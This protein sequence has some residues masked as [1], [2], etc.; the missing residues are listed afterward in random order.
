MNS[1]TS[2]YGSHSIDPDMET[3]TVIVSEASGQENLEQGQVQENRLQRKRVI[4]RRSS[5]RR[6]SRAPIPSD[7]FVSPAEGDFLSDGE[8]AWST[9]SEHSE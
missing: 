6:K 7:L 8:S 4:M 5:S 2:M 3:P 1:T 9:L